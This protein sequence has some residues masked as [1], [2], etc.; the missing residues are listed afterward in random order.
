MSL[1]MFLV[2]R[3]DMLTENMALALEGIKQYNALPVYGKQESLNAITDTTPAFC[4]L[5]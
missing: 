4:E 3:T 1:S 2:Y 5:L